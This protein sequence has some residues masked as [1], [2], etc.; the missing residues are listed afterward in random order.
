M[1]LDAQKV[2]DKAAMTKERNIRK[3]LVVAPNWIGDAVLALPAIASLRNALPSASVTILGLAHICELFKDSPYADDRIVYSVSSIST[4][5]DIRKHAFDLAV[6][7]PNSF[8]TAMIVQLARIPY[9][10]GYSRD[11]R[12]VLLNIAIKVDARVKGLTQTEYYMNIVN[13]IFHGQGTPKQFRADREREWLHLSKEELQHAKEILRNHNIPDGTLII[14]INPGAAYGSAKRW[15]PERFALV[16]RDL[17]NKYGARTIIFGSPQER[18]I[19]EEIETLA[20]APAINLAG[21]TTIRE[22]MSL[23]KQCHVFIT[24]DSGPMHMASA[25]DVPVVAIFGSTDPG[26]TGPMGGRKVVIKKNADCSPC[27]KRKCPTDLKCM[28][29]ITVEDVMAGAER[30]LR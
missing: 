14:G 23:I 11:G 25:L 9:R 24:N 12:G 1:V 8:R 21:K 19:A 18:D 2:E 13:H 28:D 5:R 20:G 6:L 3:V 4:A 27:F 15:Y 26:K 22:L 29:M 10:C 7:L 16:S 17:A 30:I